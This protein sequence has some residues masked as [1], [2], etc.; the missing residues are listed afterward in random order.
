MT[1]HLTGDGEVQITTK[2]IQTRISELGQQ[3]S[4]EY[5]GLDPHLI[6]VL[7]GAWLFHA[8]LVRSIDLPVSVDFLAVSSYGSGK[9]SSGEVRLTKDLSYPLADRHVILVEDIVD[10]GR[11]LHFFL[12]HLWAQQPASV[13]TVAFLRKPEAAAFPVRVNHI[14]YDIED[15]FVVGYGL[16]Y[17]GVGRNLRGIYVMM[18]D[19]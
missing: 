1:I 15:K 3:I 6:C 5:A 4:E 7:N 16:D 18:N 19:E 9:T 13:T 14:G 10:T 8:D 2:Q 11:T 12:E 17:D